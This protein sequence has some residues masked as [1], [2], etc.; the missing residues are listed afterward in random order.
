[1]ERI[2]LSKIRLQETEGHTS[3]RAHLEGKSAEMEA[4]RMV[5]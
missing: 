2:D 5:V 4:G 3:R 1:M